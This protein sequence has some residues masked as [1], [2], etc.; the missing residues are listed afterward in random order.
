MDL[1]HFPTGLVQI[2][3]SLVGP[4]LLQVLEQF[5]GVE[6]AIGIRVGRGEVMM[7]KGCIV[8]RLKV[9]ISFIVFSF[10]AP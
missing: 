10:R 9:E 4:V 6:V 2:F 3:F 8:Q 1:P 7:Q 5:G